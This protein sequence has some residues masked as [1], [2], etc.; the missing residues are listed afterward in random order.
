MKTHNR[1]QK[2]IIRKPMRRAEV[3]D[4]L[5][6]DLDPKPRGAWTGKLVGASGSAADRE[7]AIDVEMRLVSGLVEGEGRSPN[8]P[9]PQPN[10]RFALDGSV[11]GRKVE[12]AL[13]FEAERVSHI[14]FLLTGEVDAEARCITGD[15]TC[16]CFQPES[17][18][19]GGSRGT[20]RLVR[21]G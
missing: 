10:S 9:K 7:V 2:P 19:C 11:A 6:L 5:G 14:P 16:A 1:T 12:M 18:A 4:K 13:W 8:F 20:F 21:V 3:M 17:C 15:W